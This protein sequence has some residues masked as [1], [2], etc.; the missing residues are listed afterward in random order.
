MDALCKWLGEMEGKRK[1]EF[2]V[3]LLFSWF[4]SIIFT[5]PYRIPNL[6]SIS[7]VQS[8]NDVPK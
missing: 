2:I 5:L 8:Q 3:L 6:C 4:Y 1:A 7:V